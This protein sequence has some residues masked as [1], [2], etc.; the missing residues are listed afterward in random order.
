MAQKKDIKFLQSVDIGKDKKKYDRFERYKINYIDYKDPEF[1]KGFLN[2][3]GKILPRR[4]TGNSLKNQRRV[5]KAIKRA[6]KIAILPYTTDL[7][8]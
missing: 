2:E 7:L 4:L 5:A 8:K 1:L 3:Q 6:R